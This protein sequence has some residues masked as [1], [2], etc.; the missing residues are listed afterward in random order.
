MDHKLAALDIRWYRGQLFIRWSENDLPENARLRVWKS[1]QQITAENINSAELLASMLNP[2]SARDWWKDTASF[3]IERSEELKKEE[4]FAGKV[5]DCDTGNLAESGW[6]LTDNGEAVSPAGGLHVHTPREAGKFFFAVTWHI[7][8]ND[9]AEEILIF[10]EAVTVERGE[11]NMIRIAGDV[12]KEQCAGL[13]LFVELHGRE[14]GI[15]VDEN[16][17]PLGTHLLFTDDS[18]AW[19]EGIPFKFSIQV[20]DST[21]D[22]KAGEKFVLLT[23]YD[24]VWTGRKLTAAESNDQRD[25]VPAINTFWMGYHTNI[26]H[27]NYAPYQW[28]NYTEKLVL[29]IIELVKKELAVNGNRVYLI[30]GSMGGTGA[31]QLAMHYPD[32]FAAALAWVPVYS[33]TWEKTPGYPELS[34]SIERMRCSIGQFT[35]SDA[36]LSPDGRELLEYGNA[37]NFITD[38]AVDMP[39]LFATNG[40]RDLSIPWVNNPPFFRAVNR[41]KQAFCVIWNDGGH[42]MTREVEE[43]TTIDQL[44]EYRLDQ[45][46]AVFSNCSDNRDYGSGDPAQGDLYGWIN[47]GMSGKVLTDKTAELTAELSAWHAEI[48]YPVSCDVTFRRCQKFLLAPGTQVKVSV[49]G[50]ERVVTADENGLL[51]VKNITFSN[52]EKITVI[53]SLF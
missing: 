21:W 4:I 10:P 22:R 37:L 24:R 51:T 26:A 34:P 46:F 43:V 30:G 5:A 18:L 23:L 12:C 35:P 44:L 40:R 49:N 29:H 8:E 39:P 19:R 20:T 11:V 36:V 6:I 1:E 48:S 2:G 27:G 25:Y 45:A 41:A 16:G 15:G 47:R 3:V 52:P 31:V 14:G 42:G 32:K 13:P 28:D 7:G 9:S 53:C 17:N 38:P 50:E 33:Y